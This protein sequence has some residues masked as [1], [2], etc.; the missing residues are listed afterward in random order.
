VGSP[1]AG[2]GPLQGIP[3]DGPQGPGDNGGSSALTEHKVWPWTRSECRSRDISHL[4]GSP[5][6]PS[7][8]TEGNDQLVYGNPNGIRDALVLV[9]TAGDDNRSSQL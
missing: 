3:G 7:S 1:S 2:Y 9:V 8:A 6:S 4:Q 5:F